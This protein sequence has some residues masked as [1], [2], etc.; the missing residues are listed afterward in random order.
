M[1]KLIEMDPKKHVKKNPENGMFCVYNSEGKKVKEFKSKEDAEKYATDNH[2]A[3]MKESGNPVDTIQGNPYGDLRPKG[4]GSRKKM[5]KEDVDEAMGSGAAGLNPNFAGGMKAAQNTPSY[6]KYLA[7]VKSDKEQRDKKLEAD[8][9]S[10]KGKNEEVEEGTY[11]SKKALADVRKQTEKNQ[12]ARLKQD[13]AD[14]KSKNEE[15]EEVD[16]LKKSTIMNYKDKAKAQITRDKYGDFGKVTNKTNKRAK[17]VDKATK[18]LVARQYDEEVEQVDEMMPHGMNLSVK[19]IEKTPSMIA[20]RKKVA[21]DHKKRMDK[22]KKSGGSDKQPVVTTTESE[23]KVDEKETTYLDKKR[24]KR[25]S[26]RDMRK[27]PDGSPTDGYYAKG[28]GS[29]GRRE[30]SKFS[31]QGRRRNL[32][33]RYESVELS[34]ADKVMIN[35]LFLFITNDAQL[36]KQRITPLIKNYQRKMKKGIFDQDMAVKGFLYAVNDGI[37][38]YNKEFG[39]GSMKLSKQE[40]EAVAT[41]LLDY[42]QEELAGG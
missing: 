42:Y 11:D 41:K 27:A 12:K 37:K 1:K 34:E 19:S 32:Q 38:K 13:K 25:N 6:R 30:P 28:D 14:K 10:K 33:A 18:K 17:G 5:K 3:L 23:E 21:D 36:Y 9:A 24:N 29:H 39:S 40:K 7:K 16:E 15:V 4:I 26:A 20:Y 22:L 31:A 2:D 35:E 8:R